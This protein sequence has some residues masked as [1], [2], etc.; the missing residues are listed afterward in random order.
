MLPSTT[1]YASSWSSSSTVPLNGT[2]GSAHPYTWKASQC[3]QHTA[4]CTVEVDSSWYRVASSSGLSPRAQFDKIA[5]SVWP[6]LLWLRRDCTCHCLLHHWNH[7]ESHHNDDASVD[8]Q[9][10]CANS[11]QGPGHCIPHILPGPTMGQID[12]PLI[13]VLHL[14][15]FLACEPKL[16]LAVI[17]VVG[18]ETVAATCKRVIAAKR[19]PW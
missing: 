10:C 4:I 19:Y 7:L 9:N 12:N 1:D 6:A 2:S 17:I 11:V 8:G 3:L 14:S 15:K 16:W 5:H 18:G 13:P